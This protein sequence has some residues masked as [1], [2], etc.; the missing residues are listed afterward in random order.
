[1]LKSKL[2]THHKLKMEDRSLVQHVVCNC[3]IDLSNQNVFLRVCL[4]ITQ[5]HVRHKIYRSQCI[6]HYL[7]PLHNNKENSDISKYRRL[8]KVRLMSMSKFCP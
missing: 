4:G 3:D 2:K 8:A 1:M 6:K 7:G 5:L